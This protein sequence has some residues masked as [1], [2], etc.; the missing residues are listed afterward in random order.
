MFFLRAFGDQ[1]HESGDR[2]AS[3]EGRI[4]A[5]YDLDQLQIEWGDL[6]DAEAA[7]KSGVEWESIF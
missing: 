4:G 1:I 3:V 5:L 7:G 2:T 6:H